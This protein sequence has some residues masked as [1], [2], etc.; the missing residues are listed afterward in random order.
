VFQKFS[1]SLKKYENFDANKFLEPTY[2]NK[3]LKL[4]KESNAE[5]I[6][7]LEIERANLELKQ[8]LIEHQ[9]SEL[10]GYSMEVSAMN[11]KIESLINKFDDNDISPSLSS[12]LKSLV[13]VN[14]SWDSFIERFKEVDPNFIPR[15]SKKYPNLTQKDLEFCSLVRINISYKDIG[16]FLQI[17]H[18]SVFKKKYRISKKMELDSDIDFQ[19]YIIQFS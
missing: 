2:K 15:L 12:Q 10:L 18:E 13:T 7:K 3:V 4:E 1:L 16:N 6:K 19:N 17:S 5:L 8:K 11:E 9:K 14:K